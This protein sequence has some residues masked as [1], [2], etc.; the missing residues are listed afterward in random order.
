M[1]EEHVQ[2]RKRFR[3]LAGHYLDKLPHTAALHCGVRKVVS[4]LLISQLWGDML[5]R[6]GVGYVIN[7]YKQVYLNT[8]K[9]EWRFK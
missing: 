6:M 1:I 7:T 5:K 9:V 3:D 8:Y 2:L 4:N